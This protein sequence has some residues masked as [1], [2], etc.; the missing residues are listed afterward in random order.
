MPASI[1]TIITVTIREI[2]FSVQETRENQF[3]VGD[4]N[5]SLCVWP[6][7]DDKLEHSSA[8]VNWLVSSGERHICSK[9]ARAVYWE[10]LICQLTK[11]GGLYS[12][13]R[14]AHVHGKRAC[15]L[16]LALVVVVVV[17]GRHRNSID[18]CSSL[19]LSTIHKW[20]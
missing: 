19:A 2:A 20:R 6:T 3:A 18:D 16:L 15:C 13:S 4:T 9:Q 12:R 5:E 14:A 10:C 1:S 8:A 17:A 7:K 11:T